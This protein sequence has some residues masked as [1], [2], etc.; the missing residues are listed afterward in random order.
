MDGRLTGE[1]GVGMTVRDYLGFQMSGAEIALMKRVK[2]AF[3]PTAIL[4]PGK[5]FPEDMS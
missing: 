1:H 5:I 4:N 2:A 3:D